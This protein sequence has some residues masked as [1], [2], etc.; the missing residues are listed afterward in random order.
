MSH[1]SCSP[2]A[3]YAVDENGCWIWQGHI[4]RQGYGLLWVGSRT[5]TRRLMR[6]HRVVYEMVRGPVARGL[7]LDHLCRVRACVNP[8][9]LEPVTH[10]E[11]LRRGEGIG[12]Q[13]RRKTHC[14]RGHEF[15]PTNTV[16]QRNGA[17]NCLACR[18]IYQR[19]Y[20][21]P[22]YKSRKRSGRDI[23]RNSASLPNAA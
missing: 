20:R 1:R 22:D 11:N 19:R 14:K 2:L 17:R 4:N 18:P 16:Y 9:H 15:T 5:T 12:A 8:D 3:R 6:A 21:S 13:N 23:R 10:A 7:E